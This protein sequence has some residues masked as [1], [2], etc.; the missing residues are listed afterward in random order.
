MVLVRDLEQR[1]RKPW[2]GVSLLS[3]KGEHLADLSEGDCDEA[4]CY[5]GLSLELP[6]GTYRLRVDTSPI[7]VYEMFVVASRGWQ[8]QVF[9]LAEDFSAGGESVRRAALR[10]ISI[11]MARP[12]RGFDPGTDELRLADLARLALATNREIVSG[13]DQHALEH[14]KFD[15]P[16]LG[17]YA[18]HLLL[19][20]PKP[21]HEL[22][23][24]I[25]GNLRKLLG[26]HP[27]VEA[28][29]L[30]SGASTSSGTDRFDTPPMLRSS[31]DL[32]V[33]GTRRRVSLVSPGSV[34]DEIADDIVSSRPWLLH[35]VSKSADSFEA[36]E[37]PFAHGRWLLEQLAM[38]RDSSEVQEKARILT[39][40]KD[41]LSTLERSLLKAAIPL[42]MP[43]LSNS[44]FETDSD[45]P[46][47][48]KE[49]AARAI[50]LVD[51][52]ATS[53]ARSA[54]TLLYKLDLD[55]KRSIR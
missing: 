36:E 42:G 28:L 55:T 20:A 4:G 43:R 10:S 8:T 37:V 45:R 7:G 2:A 44:I 47:L 53:I 19:M 3:F 23:D 34:S 33:R 29:E 49:T 13:A 24:I 46:A 35:R 17:I 26:Y 31:W 9:A 50:R 38:R 6:P 22:I 14:G 54:K 48:A 1:T 11:L 52:P 40:D 5:G 16:M 25:T 27:D 12:E 21:N 30:R 15:D 39:R 32:V 18:G 51:A 41:A